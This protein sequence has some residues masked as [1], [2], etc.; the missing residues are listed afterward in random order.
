MI[1]SDLSHLQNFAESS[2]LVGGLIGGSWG[3]VQV[4]VID[5]RQLSTSSAFAI[6]YGSNATA[7]AFSLNESDNGQLIF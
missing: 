4:N 3:K 2:T 7:I 6:S 5:V 1:I